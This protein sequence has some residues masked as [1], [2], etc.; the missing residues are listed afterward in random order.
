MKRNY[1][2]VPYAMTIHGEEEIN[3][4]NKVLRSSTQMG[5]N[6]KEFEKRG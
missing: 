4:V 2:R 6:T 3:A 1:L 5:V